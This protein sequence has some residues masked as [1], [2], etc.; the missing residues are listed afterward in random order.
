MSTKSRKLR[1]F[2][3]FW[4]YASALSLIALLVLLWHLG[5][6]PV[7]VNFLR[8]YII[9]ALT[10]ETADYDLSVGSVNLELVHS[11]QPVKIIAKDVQFKDK[12]GEYLV[13]AP[14]LSLSFSA[15]ALLKGMLAPSSI[16]IERPRVQITASY[17]LKGGEDETD[18]VNADTAGADENGAAGAGEAGAGGKAVMR[19]GKAAM[20]DG[21][22]VMRGGKAVM[23]GGKAL[24]ADT[25]EKKGGKK[26]GD[27]GG[28]AGGR[29]RT[30]RDGKPLS[31]EALQERRERRRAARTLKKLEFYFT[32]FEDFMERFNSPERLY[33]ESFINNI[34]VTDAT[35]DMTEAETGQQ[36]TFTDM[37]FAFERGIADI[38][39]RA[40]SAVRF[41]NRTSAL[42]MT[43]KYRQI[44]RAHV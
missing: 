44:G 17:G 22:A 25:G 9:Q 24:A 5:K 7:K 37:D 18:A 11:V 30:G 38:I 41:E 3:L 13:E 40:D 4:D 28:K 14:R 8:P 21:K 20:R 36:F 6:G 31:P 42:D 19:G 23:R 35:L 16:T 27:A 34:S 43:L 39:I 26:I 32:Q 33:L 2:S 10:N 29:I 1:F 12:E 15:R